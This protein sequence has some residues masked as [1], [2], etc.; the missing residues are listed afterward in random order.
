MRRSRLTKKDHELI[1]KVLKAS[2]SFSIKPNSMPPLS[3]ALRHTV[4]TLEKRIEK[5][6]EKEFI[7]EIYLRF[8]LM[9]ILIISA[10]IIIML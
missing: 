9:Q 4:K 7:Y 10:I 2:R 8:T 3:L 1:K 5:R 6:K